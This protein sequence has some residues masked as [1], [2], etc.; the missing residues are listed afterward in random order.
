M[1]GAYDFESVMHYPA[2]AFA[3]DPSKPVIT[4]RPGYGSF[5]S[6]MGRGTVPS[7]TDHDALAFLYRGQLRASAVTR[8]TGIPQRT[9][10]RDEFIL[11]MERLNA[12][13]RSRYGLQRT[14]G[15]SIDGAPDFLGIAQWI[16]DIY[17]GARSSGWSA[18]GAFDIV[19]AAITR[20]DEWR[21][22][23]PS[24]TPLTPNA[25]QAA[26]TF[27]RNEFLGVMM[28]LD[29]F[30]RAPEGLQRPNGLSLNGG[31]DFTGVATWIFDVYLAERLRGTSANAAW[32]LT[33]NAIKATD[34]WR[35]KH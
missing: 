8:A 4:P 1:I 12:L 13:Y 30:Y 3:I 20:T 29:A 18:D 28:R 19:T 16:F 14:S 24:L 15:L 32:T 34:E 5:A 6:S 9:F 17:L 27:D 35:K 31:P 25:Y 23:N 21:Q 33:E 2:N 11:A 22:K 7:T 26:L 10:S